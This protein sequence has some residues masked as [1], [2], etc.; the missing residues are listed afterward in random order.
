MTRTYERLCVRASVL[1]VVFFQF[2]LI[3]SRYPS[4]SFSL[5]PSLH[6]FLSSYLPS[7]LLSFI[8]HFISLS[9]LSSISLP[10]AHTHTTSPDPTPSLPIV[11]ISLIIVIIILY[12][13]TASTGSIWRFPVSKNTTKRRTIEK[14]R[15]HVENRNLNN[16]EKCHVNESNYFS[17]DVQNET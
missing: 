2:Y 5:P 6:L 9:F 17:N 11:V 16:S 12:G 1:S 13:S 3:P 10:T 14:M 15:L 7:F 8:F 4:I